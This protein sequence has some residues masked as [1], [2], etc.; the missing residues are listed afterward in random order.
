MADFARSKI[1]FIKALDALIDYH[2][3]MRSK[4]TTENAT[5][6]APVKKPNRFVSFL[7]HVGHDLKIGLP[8]AIQIAETVGENAVSILAPGASPLFNQTV[9]M[10]ATAEQNYPASGTGAEKSAAVINVMGSLI[11]NA[12]KI[13]GLPNDASEVQKYID[14][15]VLISQVATVPVVDAAPS[16]IAIAPV[17][18]PAEPIP[19]TAHAST[20]GDDTESSAVESLLGQ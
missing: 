3:L 4:M 19:T 20:I 5:A 6:T 11:Q 7:E 10:I 8:P 9:A 1:A 14:A 2:D 13:A 15:A 16:A 12:L 18:V 17:A